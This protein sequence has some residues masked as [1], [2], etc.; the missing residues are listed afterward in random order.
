MGRERRSRGLRPGQVVTLTFGFIVASVLIFSLGLWVGYDLARQQLVKS[1]PV[2]RLPVTPP[3]WNPTGT[4]AIAGEASPAGRM[5]YRA[6][7]T[8][9]RLLSVPTR[10]P[11]V[12]VRPSPSATPEPSPPTAVPTSLPS[13]PTPTATRTRAVA[14]RWTVQAGATTDA[15]QAAILAHRLRQAGFAVA[16]VQR[17]IGGVRWY[18]VRVGSF[19]SHADASAMVRRLKE[20]EGV[21]AAYVISE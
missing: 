16:T 19:R 15:V 17:P 5:E 3:A 18:L 20:E 10:A 21:E 6:T 9:L 14:K 12:P 4:A 1:A 13:T 11:S 7:P 2:V 8:P